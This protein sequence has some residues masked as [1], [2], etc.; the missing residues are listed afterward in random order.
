MHF[1]G[2]RGENECGAKKLTKKEMQ[3]PQMTEQQTSLCHKII[4]TAAASAAVA[5]LIPVPGTGVAADML[6]MSL[7]AMSLASVFGGNLSEQVAKGMAFAAIKNTMLKQP[8]KVLSKEL[9]KLV[10]FL[11]AAVSATISVGLIEAAGWALA[12]EQAL[13]ARSNGHAS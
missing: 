6:A 1:A 2:S 5:N 11:G 13:N 12:N 10:P 9:S 4:H 8:I 3:M 7:M